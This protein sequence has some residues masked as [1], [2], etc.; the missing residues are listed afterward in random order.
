MIL[1]QTE[2]HSEIANKISHLN[3]RLKEA[4]ENNAKA[5]GSNEDSLDAF[6]SSLNTSTLSKGDITKMKVELQNL[7]REEMKLVKLINLTK[8][9]NLPPLVSQVQAEERKNDL[10]QKSKLSMRKVSQLERR[11]KLFEANVSNLF[12]Y[13]FI[14]SAKMFYL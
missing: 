3:N 4:Q 9:A 11:R 10:Q 6:M 12:S 7:R 5:G 13:S 1:F 2:K 8:P 14:F